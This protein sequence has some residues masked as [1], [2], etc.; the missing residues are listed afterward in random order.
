MTDLEELQRLYDLNREVIERLPLDEEG[1]KVAPFVYKEEDYDVSSLSIAEQVD[2]WEEER[3]RWREGHV[4]DDG[5]YLTGLH[6]FY[7]TQI[8][9]KNQRGKRIRPWWR[10]VD[11]WIIHEWYRCKIDLLDLG[12]FKRRGIGLSVLFGG[13]IPI[14]L[15]EVEKGSIYLMTSNDKKKGERMFQEKTL[16]A[17]DG[18]DPWIKGEDVKRVQTGELRVQMRDIDGEMSDD[19]SGIICKQTSDRKSDASNF[20]SERAVGAFVDELFLHPFASEVRQSIQD[21]L[22]EDQLKMGPCVFGGSAGIVSQSGIE[23]AKKMW[24]DK[25]NLGIHV[26]FIDGTWGVDKAPEYDEDGKRT[27]KVLNFCPNGH[28]KR[29][30]AKEWILARRAHLDR[31]NDK[32]PLIGYMKSHPLDPQDIFE[33]NDLGVIPEDL[34]PRINAQRI[35]IKEEN[36]PIHNY[37]IFLMDKH[38]KVSLNEKAPWKILEHPVEGEHYI[39]GADPIETIGSAD[40]SM[41]PEDRSKFAVAI[42]R[43]TTNT[44]VAYY[45]KRSMDTDAVK[46]QILA[47]QVYYNGARMML[48][49]NKGKVISQAYENDGDYS[50]LANQPSI[51][52]LRRYDKKEIKGFHKDGHTVDIIYETFFKGLRA[53]IENIWF[54]EVL[55]DL[56][57]FTLKNTDLLDAIVAVEVYDA[58][59]RKKSKFSEK[60][61]VEKQ[62]KYTYINPKTGLRDTKWVT[63]TLIEDET[64]N[65]RKQNPWNRD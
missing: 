40:D 17:F 37:D 29:E 56:P 16:T 18:L 23:E 21:C 25:E 45:L 33:F 65:F 7:L 53:M 57:K 28:S 26:V 38:A 13:A 15:S 30:E 27:G 24:D 46:A 20:E 43:R 31:A 36:Q 54:D 14:W 41:N 35:K 55:V 39:A 61:R 51:F 19:I 8:T 6:Y 64:G 3:R 44:I 9:I 34:L 47:G 62:Y 49:R 32:R 12:I 22:M 60:K 50:M 2:H 10:D 52:G 5:Y 48:E 59:L 58:E 42:K 4:T 11:E 63:E 1:N